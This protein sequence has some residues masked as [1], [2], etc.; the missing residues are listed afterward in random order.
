MPHYLSSASLSAI[1]MHETIRKVCVLKLPVTKRFRRGHIIQAYFSFQSLKNRKL[2]TLSN[3]RVP[4]V[5][6]IQTLKF[7]CREWFQN[8]KRVHP[9]FSEE[10]Y[11]SMQK[12]KGGLFAPCFVG[13]AKYEYVP[14]RRIHIKDFLL[15][16]SFDI[17]SIYFRSYFLPSVKRRQPFSLQIR[18]DPI[19]IES[20]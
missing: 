4:A 20:L 10:L 8:A 2:Q 5:V 3:L 12:V 16:R 11:S 1:L 7:I 14:M 13:L 18:N 6:M 15:S 9:H 17:L 19:H